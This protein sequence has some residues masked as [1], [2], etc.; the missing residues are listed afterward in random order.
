MPRGF[1]RDGFGPERWFE[2]LIA[3]IEDNPPR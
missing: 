1:V 3:E 2:C